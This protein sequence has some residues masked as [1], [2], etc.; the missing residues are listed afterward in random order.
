MQFCSRDLEQADLRFAAA[1][2]LAEITPL[3]F[4]MVPAVE[5]AVNVPASRTNLRKHSALKCL[6]HCRLQVPLGDARLVRHD[7]GLQTHV[8]QQ[9]DRFWDT[10]EQFELG[11]LERRINDASVLVIDKGV[12]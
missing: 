2:G 8:V 11:A 9:P 1:A 5:D 7:G 4:R 3:R 6:E 10:R 12:D